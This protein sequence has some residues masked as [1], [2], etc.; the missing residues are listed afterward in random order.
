MGKSIYTYYKERLIEIGGKNKCLYLKNIV[1]KSAYDIGRIFEG[2]EDKV[3]ELIDFL[4]SGGKHPLTLISRDELRDLSGNIGMTEIPE[5]SADDVDTADDFEKAQK[6]RQRKI[7]ADETK[8]IEAEVAKIKELKREVEEI[9]RET[10]KYELYIGYP[11]VFGSL[12]QGP[13]KTL[14]KAPLMLFPVKIDIPDEET[15]EIRYNAAEKIQINKALIFAYA[16]AKK[17]NIDDLVTEFDDLSSFRSLLSIIKHLG[18]SRVRIDCQA[19][20]KIYNYARFKEPDHSKSELSVRYAAVLGRFP[21]SNSVYNDYCVLEKK[22]LTNDAIDELLRTGGK[23]GKTNV[24]LNLLKNKFKKLRPKARKS[25]TRA[26]YIVKMLDYSQ[27]EVVK[28]VDEM[29]NMVIYG[30]PGTGK[31]Q[32]IVNVITDALCKNKRVLVVSQKKA[33]LDVV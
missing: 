30:P 4:W 9:E 24:K 19:S 16:Q 15:V 33:A 11:F 7:T 26:S 17:I 14:I 10:G 18:N 25:V 23:F 3:T 13:T 21:I 27:S 22:K 29:G 12:P 32:T 6:K 31:S 1:R 20:K 28:K 8:M 2:R 5:V